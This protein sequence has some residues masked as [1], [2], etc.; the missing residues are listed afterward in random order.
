[1]RA[2]RK[3]EAETGKTRSCIVY[4]K[5]LGTGTQAGPAENSG[6]ETKILR[7]C[8]KLTNVKRG[9]GGAASAPASSTRGAK[10]L[11]SVPT[12]LS[13][14]SQVNLELATPVER[15]QSTRRE[16][17]I[18]ERGGQPVRGGGAT[19]PAGTTASILAQRSRSAGK[20][21]SPTRAKPLP[22]TP[23]AAKT[24]KRDREKEKE[25]PVSIRRRNTIV[26]PPQPAAKLSQR[27]I[28]QNDGGA[29]AA[30]GGGGQS[31]AK[32]KM[33][34]QASKIMASSSSQSSLSSP[35]TI[36]ASRSRRSI[37]PNPKYASDDV[38]TPKYMVSLAHESGHSRS[39]GDRNDV[40]D[41]DDDDEEEEEEE[42]NDDEVTDAAFNPHLH[43]SDEDDDDEDDLSD[44]EFER[45]IRPAPIKRGR[46]RPPKAGNT[47]ATGA[48]KTTTTISASV[49]SPSTVRTAGGS[50]QRNNLHQLR[51][52]IATN[53]NKTKVAAGASLTTATTPGNKRKL[54]DSGE[55]A[56]VRK[57]V[58]LNGAANT[59]AGTP[60]AASQP[61]PKTNNKATSGGTGAVRIVQAPQSVGA[62]QRLSQ[63][64]QSFKINQA[65][66]A[67]S[68]AAAATPRSSS[69]QQMRV[70]PAPPAGPAESDDVPTFT[71]VNID[72]IIN[73][74][75]VLISRSSQSAATSTASTTAATTMNSNKAAKQISPLSRGAKM[76]TRRGGAASITTP[77]TPATPNSNPTTKRMITLGQVGGAKSRP[78][79]LNAEMG[80]KAP[81]M[82]PLMSMG[83]ELCNIDT[84]EEEEERDHEDDDDTDNV[85]QEK[86]PAKA[87]AAVKKISIRGATGVGGAAN[88][89]TSSQK[90]QQKWLSST[91]QS[92]PTRNVLSTTANNRAAG[93]GAGGISS[94]QGD[95]KLAKF[96]GEGNDEL[97]FKKPQQQQRLKENA[98]DNT[99]SKKEE[100][101][102]NMT[103]YLPAETTTFCEE[104]GRMI[105]KITC[106][107]TWHVIGSP[108][109]GS[110]GDN[111]A[112]GGGGANSDILS[113][114][115]RVQRTSLEFPLV[116]LA[117]VAGRIK[118]PSN[119]WSSKVTLY[120]VSPTL[121][122]RQTMTIF[123][124]DL[125]SFNIPEEERHK[126]QPS[127]V[128]FRRSVL[129]RTK[130][131]V[132][133]DRAIIFKNKCFYANIDGKHINLMG[134]PE[135]VSSVK[136]VEILL[137]IVDRLS[138]SSSLVETVNGK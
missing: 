30:A 88:R 48:T 108:V 107:E 29:A 94:G 78:R 19:T 75:D 118:V 96:L 93:A 44:P 52:S 61:T 119:K 35:P 34:K 97:L 95:R 129:D 37:K 133:Y 126:Y 100:T 60:A 138:L 62:K 113:R 15:R 115:P 98:A 130:C 80:K 105:K 79:I 67:G 137:D 51:R 70:P 18:R 120:K 85:V 36:A 134:A 102:T 9:E 14:V 46:G 10:T 69:S 33:F 20:G 77:Q 86:Q 23:A 53:M 6:G 64:G 8:K 135:A 11:Q 43:K 58:A 57:R 16:V 54:E 41:D 2:G 111:S 117:N 136:D 122:A 50:T 13:N 110:G 25:K 28:T 65:A 56:V 84:E 125:K 68:G 31:A 5:N 74:D 103:K 22:T 40:E 3:T 114:K 106:Y 112:S 123:T 76:Q 71:I 47:S 72:D 83:K 116:K 49:N 24:P 73:Q 39:G 1:M 99:P 92:T 89:L 124:G 127:C 42:D 17:A 12:K 128:L 63:G 87:A 21:A 26:T 45:E 132:P 131:R 4:L 121:M 66:R 55:S 32:S 27:R 7:S 90:P 81:A 104:D 38:V 59:K 91:Q 109:S 82:K 101:T